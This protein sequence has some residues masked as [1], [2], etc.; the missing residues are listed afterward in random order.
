MLLNSL[1]VAKASFKEYDGIVTDAMTICADLS[2]SSY[3]ECGSSAWGMTAD[4]MCVCVFEQVV[5][6]SV[7]HSTRMKCT[8]EVHS[9]IHAKCKS[10]RNCCLVW[11][12]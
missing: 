7:S 3:I 9:T 12:C 2:V 10:R 5:R 1:L 6:L 8:S 11:S 4:G